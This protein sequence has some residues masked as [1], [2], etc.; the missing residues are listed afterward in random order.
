M[1]GWMGLLVSDVNLK[2]ISLLIKVKNTY[3]VV[4]HGFQCH[5]GMHPTIKIMFT[6]SLQGR[7]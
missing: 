6:R 7:Y 2:S 5:I 3:V 1:D 4:C